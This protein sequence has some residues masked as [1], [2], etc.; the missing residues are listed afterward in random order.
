LVLADADGFGGSDDSVL[1]E[2]LVVSLLGVAV[3]D[4][5]VVELFERWS[6]TYHPEPLKTTPTGW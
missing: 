2:P 5:S 4:G 1:V 3:P 6:V